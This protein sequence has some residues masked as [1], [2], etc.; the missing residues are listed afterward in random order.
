MEAAPTP[1]RSKWFE[2]YPLLALSYALMA[3]TQAYSASH[4]V[5]SPKEKMVFSAI[6]AC[7]ALILGWQWISA[8]RA[9]KAQKLPLTSA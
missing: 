6:F 1:T 3:M 5:R 7:C 9:K 2:R 8:R 4:E